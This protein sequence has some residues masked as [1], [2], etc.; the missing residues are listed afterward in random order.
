MSYIHA[1]ASIGNIVF[2]AG[3]G[4]VFFTA[5]SGASWN[6]TAGGMG[7]PTMRSMTTVGKN[8][9]VGGGAGFVYTTSD[10][11]AHWIDVSGG[12]PTIE[13]EGLVSDGADLF[14]GT[15]C[16]GVVRRPLSEMITSVEYSRGLAVPATFSLTSY[17]NPFHPTT[18]IRYELP[19]SS[20]ARLSVYDMLGREVAVLVNERRPAGVHEMTF[21]GG[22][23]ASGMY[24]Y[25]LRA[26]SLVRTCRM[27]LI[28]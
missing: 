1:L 18:T 17:P 26:G 27:L 8:L 10:N 24:L 20:D 6:P 3:S 11:G 13:I 2:A 4:G 22:R 16:H 9:F 21:D 14:G 12:T 7:H 23:L 19:V 25:R 28:R 15:F 5:D